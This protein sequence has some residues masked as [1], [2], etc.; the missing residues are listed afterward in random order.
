MYSFGSHIVQVDLY[1]YCD[2]EIIEKKN[3]E[4]K[5]IACNILQT[6]HLISMTRFLL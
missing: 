5:I 1:F 2:K 6:W 4:K 3:N